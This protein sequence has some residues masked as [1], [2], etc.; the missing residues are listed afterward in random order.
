MNLERRQIQSYGLLSVNS[1]YCR[2]QHI[3]QVNDCIEYAKKNGLKICPKGSAMSFSDVGLIKDNIC[4][5]IT[6]LDKIKNF[7]IENGIIIAQAGVLTT[8]IIALTMP[9]GWHLCGLSGSLRNTL[10]GDISNNVNGK[11]SW[12]SGN[13]GSN[14]KSMKILLSSGII[15][16][17]NADKNADI[18][19]AAIGG[20]GLLGVIIEVTLQLKKIQSY[21]IETSSQRYSNIHTLLQKTN[22]INKIDNYFFYIWADLFSKNKSTGRGIIESARFVS[23]KEE[24]NNSDFLNGLVEKEKI[25]IL[26]PHLFWNL[27]KLIESQFSYKIFNSLKYQLSHKS[28]KKKVTTFPQYQYPMVKY[29]PQWNIKFKPKGFHEFQPL[30][31]T[32]NFE[33]AFLD[34]VKIC[35]KHNYLSQLCSIRRHIE[36]PYYLG[37]SGNGYS[38]TLIHPLEKFTSQKIKSFNSDLIQ[39]VLK[40]NGKLYLGKFPYLNSEQCKLMYPKYD[41]FIETKKN[42]DKMN[43][44]SSDAAIRLG[45]STHQD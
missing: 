26:S 10:G 42:Y 2:P 14:V 13:F 27:I 19:N 44:F 31:D 11:D 20:M 1:F 3:D 15:I 28:I 36:E 22:N 35:K 18:F 21:Y 8:S 40:F 43:L 29:F 24:I 6:G 17:A 23:Q 7:D 34:I 30:F 39:T 38:M 25:G 37:F 12:H 9:F 4:L 32:Q 5:D 41:L 16:E 45:L 33:E